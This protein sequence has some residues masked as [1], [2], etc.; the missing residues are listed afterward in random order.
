MAQRPFKL[1]DIG[2]GTAE[3][4]L[5]AWHV[6]IGDLVAEDE[7]LCDVMTDK[8]T[9]EVTA[10]FSGK[11]IERSGTPGDMLP[12]GGVIL[13]FDV[14]G[15]AA[16]ASTGPASAGSTPIAVDTAA[17]VPPEVVPEDTEPERRVLAS[18]ALRQRAA[19]LGI[20]LRNIIGSGAGGRI[21]QSD[22]DVYVAY[23]AT[24]M[25]PMTEKPKAPHAPVAP[26]LLAIGA[27]SEDV[28]EVPVIGLRRRIAE[29]MQDTKRRI[30]HFSYIEEVDVSQ[31][32]TLR[33]RLNASR[34]EER[35]KLTLLPFL[36]RALARVMPEFPHLN[37]LY[38]DT[39][40]IV[41]RYSA[42]HAGIATQTPQ[43]LVVT[44]LRHADRHDIWG[45]ASEL[46]RLSSLAR[47][48]RAASSDLTGS[49]ITITS[50]G[51]MGGVATTPVINSPEVAIVGVNKVVERPIVCDGQIKVAKMM[52]L[53]SSFD[54]RVV[55]GW[56]AALFVQRLKAFLETP[57]MLF[58]DI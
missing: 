54:H 9:V 45:V 50:L 8:A 18:P 34:G 43:G 10:P 28:D 15:E 14:E 16:E 25:E 27:I 30:P 13:L 4:E 33:E 20:D 22:V 41:R 35:P 49:T 26:R 23:T 42:V 47:A 58:V 3:A 51:A 44:V 53:S 6:E 57:A 48:G 52:N 1:P 36:V 39:A 11:V 31:L 21:R 32:E 37:A 19:D 46:A 7:P 2:E 12:V 38:D 17:T 56:D 24:S 55:D 40:G 5:V 29:R